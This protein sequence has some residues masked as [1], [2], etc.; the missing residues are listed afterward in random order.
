MIHRPIKI[1]FSTDKNGKRRAH[2]WGLA[3]RWLPISIAAAEF[4]LATGE[5]VPAE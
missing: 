5:A 4:K 3:L 2:Y 1:R